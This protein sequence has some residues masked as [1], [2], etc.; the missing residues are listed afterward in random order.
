MIEYPALLKKKEAHLCGQVKSYSQDRSVKRSRVHEST[1]LCVGVFVV[2]VPSSL[3]KGER[4]E[5]YAIC[6]CQR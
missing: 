1:Y 4:L 2:R 6:H 3:P 5:A